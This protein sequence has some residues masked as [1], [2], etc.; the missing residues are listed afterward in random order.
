M[1][2]LPDTLIYKINVQTNL[3][4]VRTSALDSAYPWESDPTFGL[5][6]LRKSIG[7]QF[8]LDLNKMSQLISSNNK[9]NWRQNT[10]MK[11]L[12]SSNKIIQPNCNRESGRKAISY[13]GPKLWNNLPL[14]TKTSINPNSFKH[15][16]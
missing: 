16:V 10:W 14:D 3:R 5:E 1:S 15:K 7:F 8:E 13:F 4:F 2:V 9:I 11:Y 6:N 12:P